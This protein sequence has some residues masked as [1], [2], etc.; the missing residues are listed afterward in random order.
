MRLLNH[1]HAGGNA[2]T[3]VQ[4]S[5]VAIDRIVLDLDLAQ[6]LHDKSIVGRN[7]TGEHL[8]A[9][10][11]GQIEG[12]KIV[13]QYDRNAIERAAHFAGFP[14]GVELPGLVESLERLRHQCMA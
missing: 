5:R 6:F 13:L 3:L 2:D 9:G 8:G 1:R 14:F 7:R 4:F 12:I 10:G 11:G